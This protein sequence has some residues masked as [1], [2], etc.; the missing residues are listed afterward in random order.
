MLVAILQE[1]NVRRGHRT[2]TIVVGGVLVMGLAA[3]AGDGAP[4]ADPTSPTPESPVVDAEASPDASAPAP[5]PTDGSPATDGPSP[6]VTPADEAAGPAE[7]SDLVV[8]ELATGLSAPWGVAFLPDGG[9]LIT[10]RDTGRVLRLGADG[11]LST[12][13]E[14]D[15]DAT[16][17]GGLL[18]IAVPPSDAG[19]G[20]V[21]VYLTAAEDNRVVRFTPDGPL[22]PVVTGIPKAAVHD[23]GR[24][25]FGPDGMLYIGTGDARQRQRAQD[26][27]SLAGKILRVRPDGT[28]PPDNPFPGSPVWT[29]GHRNIQGLAWTPDGTMYAA[30]FGPDRDDEINRIAPG[31]NYGWPAVTGRADVDGF[32]D[33]V[34]VRQPPDASWSGLAAPDGSAIAAWNGDLVAASLRG[35]RLW[36]I[37]LGDDGTVTDVHELLVDRFGRLRLATVAPDGS[38]WLLTNNT[39]GRGEPAPSDDRILRL[40]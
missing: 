15:V 2:A 25:A 16:G 31:A 4:A 40:R 19:G 24:I 32:V 14:I 30:E 22:E 20:V 10:E 12:V 6:T 18:G 34:V 36:H 38:V 28:V 26:P 23:G 21:Y 37:E 7:E 27:A 3:C 39:D 11:Q 5:S 29:L 8:E 9:A 35:E 13:R 1:G 17:E 33:P